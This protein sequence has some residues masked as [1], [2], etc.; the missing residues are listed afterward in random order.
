MIATVPYP[1]STFPS[2]PAQPQDARSR[3]TH[4][5][6][7]CRINITIHTCN[8]EDILQLDGPQDDVNF[9]FYVMK[10]GDQMGADNLISNSVDLEPMGSSTIMQCKQD[11]TLERYGESISLWRCLGTIESRMLNP[12]QR[13]RGPLA[14]KGNPMPL[15]DSYIMEATT[16][17]QPI[18]MDAELSGYEEV[19]LKRSLRRRSWI[20][21][22]L[23]DISS[24]EESECEK[25][26]KMSARWCPNEACRPIIDEAPIFYPN[27]E[28]FEDTLG[29]IAKIR[30]KAEPYGICRIVPP[31]SWKPPCPLREKIMWQHTKFA[32]RVQQVDKL[33]NREPMRKKSTSHSHRK[34]KR[35]RCSTME[36]TR[37]HASLESS[38][39]DEYVASD[40]D[41]KFGFHSGSD[42]TLKDFKIHADIFKEC[43]FGVKGAS[44]NLNSGGVEPNMKLEPSVQDIE[45]EYWRIIEKP[46]EEIEVYYGA[47]LETGVFGSGF[48]KASSLATESDS[49]RYVMSGW[50]LNNFSRL[51]GSVLCFEKGD[52]SGVLVP[53]LYI[54][55]CFSSFCWR[56][57]VRSTF[58]ESQKSGHHAIPALVSVPHVEDHHLYSL[59]YLHWGDPKLWYG[60]P[61]S[62]SSKLEHA[63]RKHLPDLFEE[64][65]DLLHELVT[66]L[67]P[68]VLKSEGVPVYRV[69]QHS[70]EFVLTFPR[71]YHAGFNCGFNCAEAV[72]VGPVDWLPHGQSAVELYSE[73]CRKTSVSHDK[74]LLGAACEAVR[75]L[76]DIL[77]LRKENPG[78]LRW[79]SVC[80]KDGVLTSAIKT[81]VG[82]E[83]E[84]RDRL[85][86]L[87]QFQKMERDFDLTYERE[88]FSCFYDLHLYA[89]SCK[90]SPDRFAC[91][92][93][94]NLLCSCEPGQRFILFRYNMDEFDTLVEALEGKSNAVSLWASKVLGLVDISCTDA[95]VAKMNQESEISRPECVVQKES[96]YCSQ[97][98]EEIPDINQPCTSEFHFSSEV[99][100]S[101]WLGRP[102]S[103]CA[104]QVKTEGGN[105]ILNEGPRITKDEGEVV[106]DPFFYLNLERMCDE[107][108]S[109]QISDNSDKKGTVNVAEACNSVV[110]QEKM[111]PSDV[112]KEPDVMGLGSGGLISI[113]SCSDCDSSVSLNH[114]VELASQH[115]L[116]NRDHML[117]KGGIEYPFTSGGNKLFGVDLGVPHPF[118][119]A[120]SISMVK[121]ENVDTLSLQTYLTGQSYI[122]QKLDLRVEPLNFGSLMVGKLWCSKQAIYSK[123]FRSRVK[124]FSV[125]DPTK[126]CSY[127]SEILDAGPL[128][129]LFKVTLEECPS[130]AFT[131]VTAEKCW[132]MVLERLN[133]EICRPNSLGKQGLL[134]LQP[135]QSIN[136]LEMFGFLSP[137]IVQAIE[138]LD[139]YHQCLEYWNQQLTFKGEN[140]NN[141]PTVPMMLGNASDGRKYSFGSS[142]STGK[143][144]V[145]FFGLDLVAQ[146]QDKSNTGHTL[147]DEVQTVLGGLFKKASHDEL[148]M[149]HRIFCSESWS[150]E[151]RAAFGTLVEEMQKNVNI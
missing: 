50:N 84:R 75:A 46:T 85:P 110:K 78:N 97:G 148:K 49:D 87:L 34:R 135:L 101:N 142:C 77:V 76:W 109:E 121:T 79:K 100:Q 96:P 7:H 80:G 105:V 65:P 37:R 147:V 108:G 69:V 103:L 107:H 111:C 102:Y 149:M 112:L 150:S 134:T 4:I 35:R 125:L 98:I 29:Y 145:K 8:T 117:C 22:G 63:M 13:M 20:H 18:K 52:I 127:I 9:M 1:F 95:C 16:D 91:L 146:E 57:V 106:E 86:I 54:G 41:E 66:Q 131:N 130:E 25:S 21:Y 31:P 11:F 67:S 120:P 114:S 3:P 40:T 119:Y 70:G 62:H 143:T 99:V 56:D 73:Q 53:W 144:K 115:V 59:N 5:G 132:E 93:H 51:P 113:R 126:T 14:S 19:K 44:E 33:Q 74:L 141:I 133:Q 36:T 137:P 128:G 71:A 24:E 124:F 83:Q 94:A 39:T 45:G 64:Q 92:K 68:S 90:C 6:M 26:M 43:Y 88:C 48:P 60:V 136:G 17:P 139:P 42:F 104:S 89:A 28:E 30:Q 81:R 47:D 58:V 61:G 27:D 82:M 2:K 23:F 32:T 15:L 12:C 72:N 55:M 118:S 151:W 38:D 140:L 122:T 116:M 129:P 10:R 123:G 138:A